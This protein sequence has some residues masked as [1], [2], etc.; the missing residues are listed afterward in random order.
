MKV[1]IKTY[2]HVR[3]YIINTQTDYMCVHTHVINAQMKER[4][5]NQHNT[6]QDLRHRF[7]NKKIH[8][9]MIQTHACVE[10]CLSN[11]LSFCLS[12]HI[13]MYAHV[14]MFLSNA[15]YMYWSNNSTHYEC[16]HDNV[17]V[18]F[19]RRIFW[20]TTTARDWRSLTLVVRS[21]WKSAAM[22]RDSPRTETQEPCGTIHQRSV[23]KIR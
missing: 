21:Y 11:C 8:S 14:C 12:I 2:I 9:A 17:H 7:P 4:Q 18:F 20:S 22:G 16:I 15:T 1:Q 23:C 13:Y 5:L 10:L 19:Q 6:T 3:T